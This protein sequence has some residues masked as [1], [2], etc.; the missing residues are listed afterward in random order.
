[1]I[2]SPAALPLPCFVHQPFNEAEFNDQLCETISTDDVDVWGLRLK[3]VSR[4]VDVKHLYAFA[5]GHLLDVAVQ[6]G[7]F[8][9][10]FDLGK[11]DFACQ[12]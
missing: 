7:L 3:I 4:V 5:L 10:G 8:G 2:R 12:W 1:M 6:F 11:R 9:L